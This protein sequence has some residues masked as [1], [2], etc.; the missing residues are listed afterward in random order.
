[1]DWPLSVALLLVL[2]AQ[3]ALTLVLPHEARQAE[4]LCGLDEVKMAAWVGM[5]AFPVLSLLLYL[6]HAALFAT[7]LV[8]AALLVSG[9]L[10]LRSWQTLRRQILPKRASFTLPRENWQKTEAKWFGTI[11]QSR[12][13]RLAVLCLGCGLTMI[14]PLHVTV[15]SVLINLNSLLIDP[16]AARH[17][18]L[19]QALVSSGLMT[20]SA[21]LLIVIYLFYLNLG[22][23]FNRRVSPRP[24]QG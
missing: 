19:T 11:A 9:G 21:A 7:P 20:A 6:V 14:L 23:W 17:L 16:Q 10:S 22:R 4:H 18:F 3:L 12:G 1:L 8:L 13:S 15:V 2:L 24:R 5:G